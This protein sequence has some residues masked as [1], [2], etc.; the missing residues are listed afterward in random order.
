MTTKHEQSEPKDQ[1]GRERDKISVDLCAGT[2]WFGLCEVWCASGGVNGI[3]AD[4]KDLQK[5]PP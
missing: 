1:K 3:S 5:L 4:E 2:T